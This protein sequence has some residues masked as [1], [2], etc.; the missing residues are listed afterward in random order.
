MLLVAVLLCLSHNTSWGAIGKITEDR[1][2]AEIERQKS[3][4]NAQPGLGIESLDRVETANGVIGITFQDNTQV[5]VTEHSKLLI[6]DFV[7][8]P[9]RK[10]PKPLQTLTMK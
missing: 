2:S 5:R 8:D 4:L 1:G 3:K 10:T 7:Y 6:D 9:N